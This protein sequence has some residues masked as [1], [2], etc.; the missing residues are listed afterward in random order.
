MIGQLVNLVMPKQLGFLGAVLAVAS[1][2]YGIHDSQKRE[3]EI[4]DAQRRKEASDRI[5]RAEQAGRLR[6][7]QV[8]QGQIAMAN[9][10]ATAEATGGSQGSGVASS[11]AG[12]QAD[13][14]TNIANINTGLATGKVNAVLNQDI[15]NAG[16]PSDFALFNQAISPMLQ[17]GLSSQISKAFTS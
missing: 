5:I 13:V 7:K 17:Q 8:K 14:S 2:A 11:M 6:R 16:R 3:G 4:N 10:E 12:V 15:S 9:A 1:T